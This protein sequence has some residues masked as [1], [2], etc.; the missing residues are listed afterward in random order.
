MSHNRYINGIKAVNT[1]E[2]YY[3]KY[4][5]SNNINDNNNKSNN[6]NINDQNNHS[7]YNNSNGYNDISNNNISNNNISN[8][9]NT[10]YNNFSNNINIYNNSN[11]KNRVTIF[12]KALKNSSRCPLESHAGFVV[13]E[14][15]LIINH[16]TKDAEVTVVVTAGLEKI[17][18]KA[19]LTVKGR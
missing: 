10:S 13:R 11:S 1:Y 4:D 6:S 3:Q 8:N 2:N 19:Y 14:Q 18:K 9:N 15:S 17:S 16:V 12:S 5:N 7:S